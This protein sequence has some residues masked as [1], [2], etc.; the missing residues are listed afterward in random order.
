MIALAATSA[1]AIP[2]SPNDFEMQCALAAKEISPSFNVT[3]AVM[4]DA[5]APPPD[6]ATPNGAS[7]ATAVDLPRHCLIQA[8]MERRTGAAGKPY[9]V[10]MEL[11]IP[12]GWN[13][14]LIFQ[15]GGGMDGVLTA[16]LGKPITTGSS[17]RPA[18]NQGYAVVST[19]SGHQ[20]KAM[21]DTSF[22]SD[23]EARL[24]YAYGAIG[25]VAEKAKLL[26]GRVTGRQPDRSYFIGCSNGGRQAMIAAQRFPTMFDGVL[27]GNPA[28]NLSTAAILSNFSGAAYDAAAA[29]LRTD[30]SRLFTPEEGKLIRTAMLKS[31]DD[32]DGITDGMIFNRVA[33]H[34][35]VRSLQC[36]SGKTSGCIEKSKVDAIDRAFRGPVGR[37]G[38]PLTSGWAYDTGNFGGDWLVWQT[39]MPTPAGAFTMLRDLVRASLTD[40]FSYPKFSGKLTG[41][42]GEALQLMNRTAEA[43]AMTNAT[44]TDLSTFTSKGGK[45]M[46]VTGWSDPIFSAVDLTR[47]YE[48][49]SADMATNGDK[50]TDYARL[51][52]V[53]GM[54]HCGGGNGLDDFDALA[55][56]VNWVENGVAPGSFTAGG[57]SFPGVTRPICAYPGIAQYDGKGP[58]AVADSFKCIVPNQSTH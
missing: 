37:D 54:T 24:N 25:K 13:G 9:A 50:A 48:R 55:P 6:V 3:K 1:V 2:A 57:K 15:G 39:G 33:C 58:Q 43:A 41:D 45:M 49:L 19:D 47:Y 36:A 40:Y 14:R 42:D 18:L 34:F 27:A 22:A 20:A 29:K 26:I 16:A 51:F 28:F 10:K 17:A 53:P 30:A 4:M 56:L 38:K 5:G 8:E 35:S 52:L 44:S 32:A 46:I 12:E 23:Q 7:K 31:C 21:N 11:R